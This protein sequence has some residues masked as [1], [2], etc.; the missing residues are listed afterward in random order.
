MKS[1]GFDKTIGDNI[2]T[3]TNKDEDQFVGVIY[4]DDKLSIVT[5]IGFDMKKP[6]NSDEK[7]V[8]RNDLKLLISIIRKYYTIRDKNDLNRNMER[9]VNSY[10]Y[11]KKYKNFPIYSYDY[12]IQ[13][14]INNG[15][16]KEE[17]IIYKESN[18][19]KINWNK[20]IKNEKS[21][22]DNDNLF[23][24]KFFRRKNSVL[25]NELITLLHKTCV[26]ESFE[27]WGFIYF[28]KN[29]S[30]KPEIDIKEAIKY[31]PL[32]NQKISKTFS[33]KHKEL[34]IHMLNVI[35][36]NARFSNNVEYKYG[37][38]YF[39]PVWEKMIDESFGIPNSEKVKFYPS[40]K[41]HLI[42]EN[43]YYASN[44]R[45]DTIMNYNDD[46]YI[47]D[48]KYYGKDG[49]GEQRFPATSAI[50]KQVTY[51]KHVE[52]VSD[53]EPYNAFLLP[54]E[55]KENFKYIGY[56]DI[57][58]VAKSKSKKYARIST[59]SV[60]TRFLMG[61]KFN[62]A[63]EEIK[64]ELTNEIN[65]VIDYT[66]DDQIIKFDVKYDQFKE[67][68]KKNDMW[69]KQLAAHIDIGVFIKLYEKIGT[70]IDKFIKDN[71]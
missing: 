63:N 3:S 27:K 46:L 70:I 58:E 59:I 18:S 43:E 66:K 10:G 23:F 57:D 45:P 7:S 67:V 15:Y 25:D 69:D 48:A 60:N 24:F 16:Y 31:I 5:P 28:D 38:E 32:L 65:K 1:N 19:G 2:T 20:T 35:E 53:K 71:K 12:L 6:T 40:A 39:H 61:L 17:D 49:Y 37:V 36:H 55:R 21:F 33:D 29:F 13:D 22:F 44:L 64:K 68:C 9:V 52:E 47:I 51:G 34:F 62:K 54:S 42:N 50:N 26:Y 4:K 30:D 11:N 56:A 41:W 14:Y 8:F